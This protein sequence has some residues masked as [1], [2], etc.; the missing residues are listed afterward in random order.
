MRSIVSLTLFIAVLSGLYFINRDYLQP[1][2]NVQKLSIPSALSK[3]LKVSK[4]RVAVIGDLHVGDS[5]KE[6]DALSAL[7]K[8]VIQSEPD[9]VL[10]LGD[11]TASPGSIS[12]M[13][14][15]RA[16]LARRLAALTVLPVFAVLGNYET[17]SGLEG[18]QDTLLEADIPVLQNSITKT[19][20][21]LVC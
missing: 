17:N 3:D 9:L 16:E 4:L 10:L 19:N 5:L 1:A 21:C 7:L 6:Y 20:Y 11:Y 2:M 13:A 12:N 15:H 8:N 18:W 14:F